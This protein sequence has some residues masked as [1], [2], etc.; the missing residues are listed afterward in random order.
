M[1]QLSPPVGLTDLSA[2]L[3]AERHDDEDTWTR[4]AVQQWAHGRRMADFARELAERGDR[5]AI[6]VAGRS[7]GGVVVAVGDDRLDV[8]TAA[9]VVNIRLALG[10]TASA[11]LAP[12]VVRR[13]LPARRGGGRPPSALVTFRARLLELEAHGATV[14]V[15]SRLLGDERQGP[16]TVGRDHLLVRGPEE[17]AIPVSWVGYVIG[18][19]ERDGAA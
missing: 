18:E 12:I 10:D 2:R 4:A 17:I 7:F 14:R 11:L 13:V 8:Q 6:D 3:R 9:G 5:V 16:I 19:S 1:D 15:G